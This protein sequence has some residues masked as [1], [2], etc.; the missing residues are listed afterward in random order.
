MTV[1]SNNI[2]SGPYAGNGNSD[3]FSYTFGITDKSQLNVYETNSAGVETLLTLDTDYTVA[4]V[5]TDTGG[6]ITRTA[7]NL[8]VGSTLFITGDFKYTQDTELPNQGRFF[9]EAIERALDKLTRLVQQSLRGVVRFSDSYAGTADPTLPEPKSLNVLSWDVQARQLVNRAIPIQ[10]INITGAIPVQVDTF[11]ALRS[12][13]PAFA[14]QRV[15]IVG[16]SADGIGGGPFY[17]L[18]E[19]DTSADDGG[20]TAVTAGGR[21]WRRDMEGRNVSLDMYGIAP[22]QEAA[23]TLQAIIDRIVA[24]VQSETFGNFTTPNIIEVPAGEY[25]LSTQ[26]NTKPYIKIMS[27]GF[28]LWNVKH[29]NRAFS[30]TLDNNDPVE[31][32]GSNKIKQSW[33]R[34]AWISGHEGGMRIWREGG[35][36]TGSGLYVNSTATQGRVQLG[37]WKADNVSVGGFQDG[38]ELGTLN[39]FLGLFDSVHIENNTNQIATEAAGAN[40]D[41]GENFRFVDSTIATGVGVLH[42]KS[43]LDINFIGCSLDFN[44]DI[45]QYSASN[46][47]FSTTKFTSCY[48]EGVSNAILNNTIGASN[49]SVYISNCWGLLST[50]QS[51]R[52]LK[53]S[54]DVYVDGLEVRALPRTNNI[55]SPA[56]ALL[57]DETISLYAKNINY[58][59]DVV[60]PVHQGQME[61]LPGEAFFTSSTAGN[62]Q[63]NLTGWTRT[64]AASLTAVVIDTDGYSGGKSL[65]ITPSSNAAN[66]TLETTDGIA[67]EPGSR[68]A[69]GML[70]KSAV[71]QTITV[72][73]GTE[74]NDKD[75]N[76]LALDTFTPNATLGS[77][78]GWAMVPLSGP[79]FDAGPSGTDNVKFRISISPDSPILLG[80][81]IVNRLQ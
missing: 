20:V 78:D 25:D 66:L 31:Q 71:T 75:G 16:H 42:R 44:S 41:F 61:M 64:N 2:T 26:V 56:D 45:V 22:G 13:E 8:P 37:R 54:G 10:V 9:P 76:R 70:V 58:S 39:N 77:A 49:V 21:R 65:Q 5:G 74:F 52:W 32:S 63:D 59:R 12:L 48:F 51:G 18:P 28:V 55:V 73:I 23:A 3:T 14:G 72:G 29:A 46:T 1:S 17:A 69:L 68:Y 7:G 53:G 50:A 11:D 36:G 81:L 19:N 67:S 62:N 27:R 30:C 24:V 15:T 47:G 35:V 60:F 40:A 6:T 38:V 79:A 57:C 80:G 33:A 34:G 4:N 43:G